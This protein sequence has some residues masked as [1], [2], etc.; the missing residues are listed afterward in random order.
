[1][2]EL[3]KMKVVALG[4]GDIVVVAKLFLGITIEYLEVSNSKHLELAADDIVY[5]DECQ[6]IAKA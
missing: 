1:M 5:C 4:S 6:I 3:E 2:K